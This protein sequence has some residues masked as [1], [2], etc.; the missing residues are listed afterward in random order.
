M[1]YMDVVKKVKSN[2][3]VVQHLDIVSRLFLRE[4]S[5]YIHDPVQTAGLLEHIITGEADSAHP[6]YYFYP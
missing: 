1:K 3:F 5:A 4:K 6:L 2:K